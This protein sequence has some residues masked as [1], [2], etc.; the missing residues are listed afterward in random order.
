[1][2]SIRIFD[3]ENQVFWVLSQAGGSQV[4]VGRGEGRG[5]RRSQVDGP[6]SGRRAGQRAGGSLTDGRWL[7]DFFSKLHMVR[8]MSL[9][10][11][12]PLTA[13]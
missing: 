5:S 12:N 1:M 10:D 2:Y 9:D 13:K 8:I 3:I 7:K 6:S 4:G 11:I